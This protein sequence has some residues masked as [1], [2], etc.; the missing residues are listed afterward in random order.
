MKK[1][2]AI[3]GI[4]PPTVTPLKEGELLDKAGSAT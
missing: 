1:R 4:I 2:E 3:E